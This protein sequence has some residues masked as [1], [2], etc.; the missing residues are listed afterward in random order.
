MTTA[1]ALAQRYFN[2]GLRLT[3]A[4]NHEEAGRAYREAAALDS[5]CAMAW[6]GQALVLGPNINMP[7]S[8]DAEK[9]AYK[10][11]QRAVALAPKASDAERAYIEAL[12]KRY[13]AVPGANRAAHDSAYA[14]AMRGVM[15]RFPEDLDA[16]ALCAEALMDLRP[17]D[18]WTLDGKPQPGALEITSILEGVLR[19][20]PDH[21]GALHYY[22]HAVEASPEPARAEAYADRLAKLTP[23]AGHLIHMPS[24]IYMRVGRYE[25]AQSINARAI[26]ADRDYIKK[27]N[28][29]GM[30]SL[31]Y[32]PHNLQMRW[33][34]LVSQG[35]RA[36]SIAAAKE[37]DKAVPDS[38][39][40]AVPMAEFFRC[41][42]YLT[43]VRFGLWEEILKDGAPP[44]GM[45]LT[46]AAWHY[47]R[48]MA[49]AATSKTAAAEAER[50]SVA[51]AA[52]ALPAG[53]VH[54]LE[55][56]RRHVPV[57]G[58]PL[59][60]R[61]RGPKREDG[62]RDP[63]PGRRGGARGFAS[64]RRAAAMAFDRAAI[65]GRGPCGRGARGGGRVGLPRGSGAMRRQRLVA[66]R[67]HAGPARAE[68]NR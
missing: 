55:S 56:G 41:S 62:R 26:A 40:R 67:A 60:R 59:D 11:A 24:H 39:I 49:L 31:M 29:T 58:C 27:Q 45:P 43:K 21:V 19:K 30:Y 54:E 12:A 53:G 37:L 7:M 47:A 61:D 65:A 20:N 25:D 57:R 33:F 13:D 14:D 42:S 64:I 10:F 15:K 52:A 28:I 9:D 68:E 16:A 35:R 51:A 6:W 44:A 32:Y 48:G 63:A 23:Y 4:F 2:Q 5:N 66:L 18:L 50:D 8:E 46:T 22:I 34:A 1:N 36:E 38:V 17:W 3:Y